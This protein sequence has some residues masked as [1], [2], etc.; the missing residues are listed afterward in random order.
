MLRSELIYSIRALSKEPLRTLVCLLTLAIG[1]GAT[2]AVFSFVNGVLLQP[3]PLPNASRLVAVPQI[4]PQSGRRFNT[5]LP[6]LTAF[7]KGSP[8]FESL[9]GYQLS[10][11]SLTAHD[12]PEQIRGSLVTQDFFSTLGTNA[13]VGRVF[14]ESDPEGAVI[15]SN[16]LWEQSFRNDPNIIGRSIM[17]DGRPGTI[18]GVVPSRFWFPTPECQIWRL[19]TSDFPPLKDISNLHFLHVIGRLRSNVPLRQAQSQ[20]ETVNRTITRLH[21]E[22]DLNLGISLLPL[23]Q[24]VLGDSRSLLLTLMGTVALVLLVACGNVANLQLCR[25]L[26]R[27]SELAIR[28]TLGARQFHLIRLLFSEALLLTLSGGSIGLGVALLGTSLAMKLYPFPI[29]LNSKGIFDPAIFAFALLLCF[30]ISLALSLVSAVSVLDPGL[31]RTLN[32][33]GRGST[34]GRAARSIQNGLVVSEIA[35]SFALLVVIVLM[36]QSLIRLSS[37]KTG[38]NTQQL[39]TITLRLSPQSYPDQTALLAFQK[40]IKDRI[41]GVPGVRSVAASSDVPL[42]NW[43][44]NYFEINGRPA[45]TA[46]AHQLVAQSSVSPGYFHTMGIAMLAGREFLDT[47]LPKTQPVA[48]INESLARRY[49]GP[50]NPLG[51]RIRHGLPAGQTRWYTIVGLVESTRLL[52]NSPSEPKIYT[53]FSQVPEGYDGVLGRPITLEIRT[54][55]KSV[56]LVPTLRRVIRDIDPTLGYDIRSAEDVIAEAASQPRLRTILFSLFGVIAS[57]LCV[58]GIYGVVSNATVRQT[59]DFGIRLALGATPT[60]VLMLVIRRGMILTSA[61]L[62]V[63]FLLSLVL[64]RLLRTLLFEAPATSSLAFLVPAGTLA[65]ASCIAVYLPARKAARIDPAVALR[66]Y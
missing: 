51:S 56:N 46:A 11:F 22:H 37:I 62:T 38:F 1:I 8:E 27:R 17:V 12:P 53:P 63:G 2:T 44:K 23:T 48:I 45:I 9:A 41:S 30:T 26:Q 42:V 49:W 34:M 40:K 58:L 66:H 39:L 20:L 7:Q 29:P 35:A 55:A 19:T 61:G 13:A 28:V 65:L 43:F 18:L 47:D 15:I 59:R 10:T 6:D 60:S 5:S 31:T 54:S 16:S 52:V 14:R 4:D 21:R 24:D 3:L 32:D 36:V 57:W 50:A 33:N 25:S 64:A